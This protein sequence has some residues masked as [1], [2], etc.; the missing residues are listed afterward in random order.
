MS[1]AGERRELARYAAPDR[2]PS[3]LGQ[4]IN[5]RVA[6]TDVPAHDRAASIS[7]SATSS[8]RPPCG[9]GRRLH[10]RIASAAAS[11]PPSSRRELGA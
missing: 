5:G 4:R 3:P 1:T 9:A 10:R 2:A 6:I 7:S 11:P 8:P